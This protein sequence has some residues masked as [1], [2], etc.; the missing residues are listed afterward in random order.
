MP[1]INEDT[2]AI[3][4]V[5]DLLDILN[6]MQELFPWDLTTSSKS[7]LES[8]RWEF[9]QKPVGDILVHAKD[10]TCP[11]ISEDASLAIVAREL[12]KGDHSILVIPKSEQTELKENIMCVESVSW[13]VTQ[14]DIVRF[15]ARNVPWMTKMEYEKSVRELGLIQKD[16]LTV[17]HSLPTI[18]AFK[19]MHQNSIH[20]VGV[21]DEEGKLIANLSASNIKGITR[22][23]FHLLRLSV[24]EF[25]RRDGQRMWWFYPICVKETDSLKELILLF[26]ATQKHRVYLVDNN[27]KPIGVISL[28]DV[29]NAVV[30]IENL[31]SL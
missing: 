12:A 1:V 4:G 30:T 27:E 10:R 13:L 29:L 15:L 3:M 14:S 6:Y 23:S 16:V 25:L 9:L 5:L 21:T 2:N 20:G 28:T 31:H 8:K 22:R 26:V 19:V 18:E 11:I 24:G 7:T 17:P